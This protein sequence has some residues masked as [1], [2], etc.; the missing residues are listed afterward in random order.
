MSKYLVTGGTGFIGSAITKELI[1]KGFDVRVFDNNSRGRVSRLSSFVND[2]EFIEGDIRDETLLKTSLQG[3]SSVIHLA[4]VNGTVNFYSKPA[5]VLDIA[6]RGMQSLVSGLKN[7]NASSF[8]LASSSEVYQSPDIF[9]TP[10]DVP[11]VVP[12]PFN[13]RYSYGLG[14]IVQEFMVLNSLPDIQKKIVFRPHNIYGPD[15]G[16]LHVVPQLFD[17]IS[18]SKNHK[19]VLNGDGSQRRSFCEIEDFVS[20]FFLLL[21]SDVTSGIYNI[22]TEY[23][24]TILEVAKEIARY[25]N[26]S[27]EFIS[28]DTPAGETN[29]RIPDISKLRCLGFTPQFDL[30]AGISKFG[31]WYESNRSI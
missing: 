18:Q 23:E 16:D 19:V 11:L 24:S 15:M 22:G 20:G 10:E 7:S 9:P 2:F 30:V 5:E 17:K 21:P 13:P 29:R 4:Y 6:L 27:P 28:G 14:K 25:L 8:Y 1:L 3:V 26:L 31:K 12:D